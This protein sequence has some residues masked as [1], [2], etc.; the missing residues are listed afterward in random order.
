VALSLQQIRDYVRAALDLE[1]EDMPDVLLDMYI[2]E[3]SKRIERAEPRWPFYEVLTSWPLT[4]NPFLAYPLTSIV[5]NLDQVASISLENF[6]P[7]KWVGADVYSEL[8]AQSPDAAGRPVY[9][10]Q[11]GVNLL[12][13]P[14]VDATYNTIVRGYRSA[15]D[16]VAAGAGE[17]PDMPDEL[18]NTVA[19]W[20]LS[21]AYAQQEDPELSAL[22]ERQFADELNEFRRRLLVTPPQ[23]PLVLNGG[24]LRNDNNM[25][26]RPRFDWE[27]SI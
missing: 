7:L 22:Y 6:G 15:T 5:A 14:T 19:T 26:M 8:Q 10:T 9:Y 1:I 17:Q 12:F 23:Q 13:H 3:G 11:W 18:H 25:L 21:K 16:W 20:A 4:V 27:L 24:A 2:R